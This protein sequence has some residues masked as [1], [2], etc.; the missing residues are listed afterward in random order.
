MAENCGC[1]GAEKTMSLFFSNGNETISIS[2]ILNSAIPLKDKYWFVF[3]KTGLLKE[4]NQKIAIDLAEIVLP[5]YE[6]RY[7]T[8]TAV[9]ECIEAAKQF[10]AG[11]ISIDVLLEKRRAAYAA[12]AAASYAAAY[13]AAAAA[14]YAAAYASS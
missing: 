12:A 1:Y 3:R 2:D 5:I 6:K 14:A 8:N 9:R 7:P 10:I 11:H 13:A 4:I